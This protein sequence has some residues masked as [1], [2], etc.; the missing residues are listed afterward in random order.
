MPVAD[1]DDDDVDDEPGT[2]SPRKTRPVPRDAG[3]RHLQ[4]SKM[5]AEE[6]K[7]EATLENQF[8]SLQ[9]KLEKAE[10]KRLEAEKEA[11]GRLMAA[12]EE[13]K[14]KV[15]R[16]AKEVEDLAA[17][18]AASL[19]TKSDD[20]LTLSP[21]NDEPGTKSATRQTQS[22]ALQHLQYYKMTAEEHDSIIII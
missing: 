15:A 18:T 21:V 4:N 9:K 3:R 2:K 10:T 5:T 6:K 19:S 20:D 11:E 14:E 17:A 7:E 12:I 8:R 16:K 13:Y 22:V 1:D